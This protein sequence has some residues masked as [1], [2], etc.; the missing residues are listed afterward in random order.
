MKRKSSASSSSVVA[1]DAAHGHYHPDIK[2]W[3]GWLC[4]GDPDHCPDPSGASA[5]PRRRTIRAT[6]TH[7]VD[8]APRDAV[9]GEIERSLIDENAA[10]VGPSG[11]RKLEMAAYDSAGALA[12]GLLAETYWGRLVIS[13]LW[14]RPDVRR[15]GIG[16]DLL[17]RAEAEAV[18][19]GCVGAQLDTYDWQECL[20]FGYKRGYRVIGRYDGIAGAH[21]NYFMSKTLG[22]TPTA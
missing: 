20:A 18:R 13:I 5:T 9:A 7:T 12:G 22:S 17:A 16:S 2:G 11:H 14:V 3:K 19:R 8:R 15:R 6:P 1:G 4:V 10:A 21:T